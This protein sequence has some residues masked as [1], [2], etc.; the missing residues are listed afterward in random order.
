MMFCSPGPGVNNV[1]E[2]YTSGLPTPQT[3]VSEG[4]GMFEKHHISD[5]DGDRIRK[6]IADVLQITDS[7]EIKD[8]TNFGS[9][10]LDSLGSIEVQQALMVTLNRPIPHNIL[11]ERPTLSALCDFLVDDLNGADV[12]DGKIYGGESPVCYSHSSD[13]ALVLLQQCPDSFHVSLYLVHE[14]DHTPLRVDAAQTSS[15]K[16]RGVHGHVT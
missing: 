8:D 7:E 9:L 5:M 14:H 1:E 4:G 12:S 6:I 11:T 3:L 16:A 13:T 2:L 15:E 10:D